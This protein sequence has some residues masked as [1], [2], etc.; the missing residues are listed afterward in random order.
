MNEQPNKDMHQLL[1]ADLLGE[2]T[3]EEARQVAQALEESKEL[4]VER[5][6]LM[7]TISL[8]TEQLGDEPHLAEGT[9]E[10]VLARSAPGAGGSTGWGIRLKAAAVLFLTLGAWAVYREVGGVQPADDHV[11]R[12]GTDLA[13]VVEKDELVAA[14]TDAKQQRTSGGLYR[15]P[16]DTNAPQDNP[17]LS[18]KRERQVQ[19]QVVAEEI[20]IREGSSAATSAPP[21]GATAV[22][23]LMS[24]VSASTTVGGELSRG[25]IVYRGPGAAGPATPGSPAP[26]TPNQTVALGLGGGAGNKYGGRGGG[27]ATLSAGRAVGGVERAMAR[28]PIASASGDMGAI[29][30]TATARPN[31][32]AYEGGSSEEAGADFDGLRLQDDKKEKL[33]S[34]GYLSEPE[35]ETDSTREGAL[36]AAER[37]AIVGERAEQVFHTCMRMPNEKPSDMYFRFWGDN[38]FESTQLDN[39]STFSV[40]VDTASYALAR[41]TLMEGKLPERAQI[42]TEEFLNY[43]KPDVPAPVG[44]PFAIQTELAPSLFGGREDRWLL[45]VAVRGRE[46][47]DYERKPVALTFVVDTS[48]SMRSGGRLEMVKKALRQLLQRLEGIDSVSIVSFNKEANEVLPRTSAVHRGLIENALLALSPGGGTDAEKGLKKGFS[49]ALANL[50]SQ[51]SN[52]VVFLSDGMANMGQ[53][54]QDRINADIS[55]YREQGILLNTIGVG[56]GGVNDNF[57]EQL[58]DKGDGMCNYI[59]S[60]KE[61]RRA[62]VENFTGTFE[63]IARDVKIQVEFDA[64]QVKR[65]RLLGYENRAIADADFRN[66][67]VDAGEVG[68][69]HQVVALYELELPSGS[70]AG[71]L[72]TVNLRW[73]TPKDAGDTGA[74]RVTEIAQ[75]VYSR[76]AAGSFRAASKGYRRGVLVAQLAE[77]LRRSTHARGDSWETLLEEGRALEGEVGDP[78]VTEF[79]ALCAQARQALAKSPAVVGPLE[80]AIESYRESHLREAELELAGESEVAEAE[81][82]SLRRARPELEEGIRQAI[83]SELFQ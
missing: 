21:A 25:G 44:V 51:A 26:A 75:E 33:E 47:A 40:D 65:Y 32:A 55:S 17:A 82:A 24:G 42:R 5:D 71:A 76:D 2:T 58:A 78:D 27:A 30:A 36:T 12:G 29:I 1:V 16:G 3:P 72:A 74:L 49:V 48:G 54:D 60:P 52:R 14:V 67:A 6:R 10:A 80:A 38:A 61:A 77:Y 39:L 46:V 18:A 73:K 41:R 83:S 20:A 4:R 23:G 56:M 53:T 69:G 45:R 35:G 62:L 43:F 22:K 19:E 63:A 70:P 34:L 57:L 7:A 50:D 15:G 31:R 13:T 79:L 59:D 66:D 68:A 37:A 64:L 28:K 11:H 8:V 9:A 81:L